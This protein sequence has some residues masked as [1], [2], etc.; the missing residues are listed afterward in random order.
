MRSISASHIVEAFPM[1]SALLAGLM[2]VAAVAAADSPPE[3]GAPQAVKDAWLDGRLETTYA[4]N[5]H[6]SP[7]EID[8]RVEDG[9]V[10]LSGT[11]ESDIEHDLAIRI[12]RD[13]EGVRDVSSSL[14]VDGAKPAARPKGDGAERSFSQRVEDATTTARVRLNLIANGNTRGLAIEVDTDNDVVTL[15]G[16]VAS[17]KDR[18]LAEMIARNTDGIASVRNQLE[19]NE[20]S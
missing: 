1:R 2:A 15:R 5:E 17:R 11:V 7:F 18:M 8:A 10:R 12:A 19:I 9:V 6:L 16:A 14:K 20:Q 3:E 4:L 13:L